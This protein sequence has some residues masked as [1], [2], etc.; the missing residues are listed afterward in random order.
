MWSFLKKGISEPYLFIRVL[1][2][3]FFNVLAGVKS[4]VNK[5]VN[6]DISYVWYRDVYN[7][8]LTLA[9]LIS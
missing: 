9:R 6:V 7:Y 1:N 5:E 3:L 8:S 2:E 4:L